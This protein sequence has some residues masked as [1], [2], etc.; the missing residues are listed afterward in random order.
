VGVIVLCDELIVTYNPVINQS[1]FN[2]YVE[3][4]FILAIFLNAFSRH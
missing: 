3:R 4:C 2:C 1:E